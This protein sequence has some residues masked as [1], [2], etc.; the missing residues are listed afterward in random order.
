M[1]WYAK[2]DFKYLFFLHKLVSIVVTEH[3]MTNHR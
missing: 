2:I 3:K 1:R